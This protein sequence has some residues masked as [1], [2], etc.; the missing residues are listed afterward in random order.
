M[1]YTDPELKEAA[2][3]K[4][5]PCRFDLR[6]VDGKNCVTPVKLQKPVGTCWSFSAVAAAETSIMGDEKLNKSLPPQG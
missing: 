2:E 3:E 1:D 6:N 5:Y 4:N